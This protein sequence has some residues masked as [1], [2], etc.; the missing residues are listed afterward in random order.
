MARLRDFYRAVNRN[1]KGK[2]NDYWFS[3]EYG[4]CD[5]LRFYTKT[6]NVKYKEYQRLFWAMKD[7]FKKA[8]LGDTFPFNDWRNGDDSYVT[9]YS[10]SR[11]YKNKKRLAWIQQKAA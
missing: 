6:K 2:A 7:Q 3:T 4:L 8:G 9:E 11:L 5:N 1:V 10:V